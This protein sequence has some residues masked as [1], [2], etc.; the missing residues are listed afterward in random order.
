MNTPT[1]FNP[2]QLQLLQMFSRQ[3]GEEELLEI[4]QLLS[5]YFSKKVEAGMSQLWK[6]GQWDNDKNNSI[7]T[8]HLRT[9]YAR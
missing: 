7:L 8:Q 1:I 4:K 6:Q 2:V 3:T 9:P 5:E